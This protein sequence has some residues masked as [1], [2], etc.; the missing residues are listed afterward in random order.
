MGSPQEWLDMRRFYS[1]EIGEFIGKLA[2][3]VEKTAPGIAHSSN[4]YA[5]KDKFGFDYMKYAEKFVDYP[6]IG[7]YPGYEAGDMDHYQYLNMV[8]GAEVD[9]NEKTYVVFRISDGSERNSKRSL[10]GIANAYLS[11]LAKSN[12][13]GIGMDMENNVSR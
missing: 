6:G 10:W 1:D 5:E 9:R 13:D 8:Y 11:L 3:I 7:F 12:A 2:S 4:H